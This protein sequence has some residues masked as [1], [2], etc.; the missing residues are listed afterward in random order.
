MTESPPDY[1]WYAVGSFADLQQ[2]D[3]FQACPILL[4]NVSAYQSLLSAPAYSAIPPS[5]FEVEIAIADV[6]VVSQSCD[7]IKQDCTQVLVCAH[8]AAEEFG[9]D[10]RIEIAKDRYVS[11]HMLEACEH[12]LNSFGQRVLDFRVVFGLPKDY[13]IA[14]A[15]SRSPRVRLL[16]PY[17]EH[18]AQAFARYF[19]RVGLPRNLHSI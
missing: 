1:P 5:T 17:R 2:G 15:A 11:L 16:P 10:K 18:M 7:L 9:R 8:R 3:L 6:V 14:L 19:M 13:L 12:G 4:P